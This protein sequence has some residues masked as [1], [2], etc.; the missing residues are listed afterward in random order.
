LKKKTSKPNFI[1]QNK[2]LRK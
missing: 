2:A 1:I